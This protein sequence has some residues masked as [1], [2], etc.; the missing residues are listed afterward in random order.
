[1]HLEFQPWE[2]W[3][4]K[5]QPQ[6]RINFREHVERPFASGEVF[7]DE[8]VAKKKPSPDAVP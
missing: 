4:I 5:E 1:M 6:I 2:P 3:F 7:L 8:M